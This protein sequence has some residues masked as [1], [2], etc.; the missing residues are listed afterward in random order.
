LFLNVFVKQDH[1]KKPTRKAN[2]AVD[3]CFTFR[4]SI[5]NYRLIQTMKMGHL[6]DSVK[7][8]VLM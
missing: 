3:F 8:N 1:R 4:Q 5:I 2:C 6:N 7:T